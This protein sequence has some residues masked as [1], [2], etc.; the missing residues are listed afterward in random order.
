LANPTVAAN[1]GSI[2]PVPAAAEDS[3][4][5]STAGPTIR[6]ALLGDVMLGRGIGQVH[7]PST[8]NQV[9]AA[10]KPEVAV[11][12]L[13]IDNLESPVTAAPLAQEGFDLR[14]PPESLAALTSA[15]LDVVTLANNHSRDSGTRGLEETKSALEN[16]GL[17][18]GGAGP[19]PLVLAIQGYRLV[20]IAVDDVVE[21]VDVEELLLEINQARKS[22]DLVVDFVI[23]SIHWGIEYTG[24]PTIREKEIAHQMVES[25]ADIVYGHHP[26]VL[27]PVEWMTSSDGRA[28]LIAYSLGNAV[29]DQVT[30]PSA[31]RGAVLLVDLDRHGTFGVQA[32]P[33]EID[34]ATGILMPADPT[35]GNSILKRLAIP[36][37]SDNK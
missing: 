5:N 18:Y 15:G 4:A 2:E 17:L 26:H 1:P 31:R 37:Q 10:V 33:F 29:F 7:S 3:S 27:Q 20:L 24:A 12:D 22:A 19:E 21:P 11:A 6:I 30:P 36:L 8:W 14:A 16:A 28:C 9:F 32:V 35:T 23:V 34:V 25:G 13:A